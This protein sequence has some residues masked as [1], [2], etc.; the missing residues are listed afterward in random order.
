MIAGPNGGGKSTVGAAALR[1]TGHDYFDPD[2]LTRQALERD[3]HLTHDEANSY[4]WH[5]GRRRLENAIARRSGYAFETTLGG[6]TITELLLKAANVG[7]PVHLWYVALE[8]VDL[9]V[10]R[11]ARRVARGGHAIPEARIRA[12]YATSMENLVRLLPH[13][14]ELSLYDNSADNDPEGGGKPVPKLLL[15]YAR[16]RILEMAAP[17]E[18]PAWAKPIIA[19]AIGLTIPPPPA[20]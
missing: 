2:T 11:V 1:K 12:R 3:P 5:E 4:A 14:A 18:T 15:H 9:H 19:A 6:T 17:R 16:G 8:S 13:L 20:A 7:L 10:E